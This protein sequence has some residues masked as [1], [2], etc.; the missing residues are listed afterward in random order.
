MTP[1]LV[2]SE[3]TKS[4]VDAYASIDTPQKFYDIAKSYLV[5]NYAGEVSPLVSRDGNTIDAG[6]YDVVVSSSAV[7]A[8]SLSSNTLTLK[9]SSFVGDIT[10][11]GSVTLTGVSY[12]GTIID[13]SGTRSFGSYEI[14][15]LV[16]GSRVQVYNLTSSTEIY[17]DIVNATA[18]SQGFGTSEMVGGDS[19]RVRITY[20]SGTTAKEPQEILATCRTPT[21]EVSASQ[22]DATTYNSY[23]LDGSSVNEFSLDLA[24]GKI[25]VDIS[26][27]NNSTNIQRVG[28]W[29]YSELMTSNGIAHLFDAINWV[30]GNQI[31]IDQSKV[32]LQID[33]KKSDPL[34]LTGGR[35]YRLD[36]TTIIASTSNSIQIDYS[37]VYITNAP[38][39]EIIDKNTKLIPALL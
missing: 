25:E 8:F 34:V 28:A 6:S 14:K 3:A 27:S 22:V 24:N 29:Y 15:N 38:L 16:S 17:N 18:L 10:T 9:A 32:N 7:N 12:T 11:S 37:P 1:D 36:E 13:S 33:N 21:W 30:A 31:A 23:E 35:M 2:V 26:D 20:Q 19:I 5:D 4:V 39:I